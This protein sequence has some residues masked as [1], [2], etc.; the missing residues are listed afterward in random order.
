[1]EELAG[2]HQRRFEMSWDEAEELAIGR[3]EWRRCVA[4]CTDYSTGGTKY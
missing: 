1:M 4:G 2:H 3:D